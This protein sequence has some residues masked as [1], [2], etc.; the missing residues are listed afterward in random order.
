MASWQAL[1]EPPLRSPRDRKGRFVNYARTVVVSPVSWRSPSTEEEVSECV[2]GAAASGRRVRVIGAGHSWSPIA[3]PEDLALSLGRLTGIIARGPDWVR[4]RSGTR[5]R[6]LNRVLAETGEA[7]PIL[8]S[9]SEPSIGGAVATGTHGSSLRHGNLSSLVLGARLVTGDGSVLGITED[10]E[11]L[12][13]VRVH[14]GALGAVTELTLRTT[15]SFRLA[16]TVEQIPIDR[17]PGRVEELG[18]S[19]EYVKVWWMPHTAKALAFRYE[20]TED[21][22]TRLPSPETQRAI[23]N[24]LPRVVLPPLFAW[25]EFRS[26]GVPHFNRVASWWLVK[27]RRVGP[28]TVML[29]TPDPVRHHETEA[30]VPLTAGGEAFE[31]TVRMIARLA[32]RVNFILELRYVQGD[33]AWMSPAY[34][35]DVV[36]LGACTAITG[37][38][39]AYFDAF[40]EEMRQLGGRPHWGKEMNHDVSEIRSLYPMAGRFLTLRDE[41]DPQRLFRNRFLDRILG[42]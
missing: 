28:S 41:L 14:L 36:H 1:L 15:P 23:E 35:G 33:T 25:H 8:G 29:S 39:H 38:R 40:W 31:R 5:I 10:D 13:A 42:S 27:N 32:L 20:R 7:L 37:H 11:R 9:I 19:A 12:D 22:G 17:V 2:A 18:R 26:D 6:D 34:G 30:A 16:E 21:P 24:W 4:V 3:A